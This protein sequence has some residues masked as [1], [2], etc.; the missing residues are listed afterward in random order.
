MALLPYIPG[1]AIVA[2]TAE[3]ARSSKA[4]GGG[5]A[6]SPKD[7]KLMDSC[8]QFEGQF[9]D[10]MLQE[11]RKTVPDDPT[12]GDDAHEQ[13]IFQGMMDDNVA[14][15]MAKH[16][17][18]NDLAAQMYKQLSAKNAAAANAQSAG[19]ASKAAASTA[20]AQPLALL[21]KAIPIIKK[22]AIFTDN[23][24]KANGDAAH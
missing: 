1:A 4:G 10:M 5:E 14:Q 12:L 11:M 19:E 9:F 24:E 2:P 3:P 7:A 23:G 17:G 18:S 6:A 8:K 13:Q 21:S 20:L 22:S 15:Q 16:A